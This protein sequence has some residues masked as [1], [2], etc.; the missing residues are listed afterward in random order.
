[1]DGKGGL[2]YLLK[3]L[4]KG[5]LLCLAIPGAHEWVKAVT[6]HSVLR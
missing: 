5:G 1:M 2:S 4:I 6:T 3:S